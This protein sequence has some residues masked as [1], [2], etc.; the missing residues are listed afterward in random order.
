M[1]APILRTSLTRIARL[2]SF[3][4]HPIPRSQWAWG[5]YVVAEV[6]ARPPQDRAL[7]LADGRRMEVVRGDLVMG[8]FGTRAATLEITGTW[9]A[10]GA[11]RRMAALTSGGLFGVVTS[12]SP[13]IAPPIAMTYAGH[14]LVDGQKATMAQMVDPVPE[15][16]W[17]VPTILIVGSSM[18]AGKT[19]SARILIRR[20]R[21]LG[22]RVVAAKLTGAG[23][24]HDA[25][26]M[27]DAGAM[28][29]FDFVDA[30][31]PSTDCPREVFEPAARNLLSRMA[32]LEPDIAVIEA[33]ASP[34]E[35][36]NG[37][38]AV[39]LIEDRLA[40]LV[41]CASDPYAA[42][43]LIDAF[44]RSPDLVAGIAC[45]TQAGRALVKRLTSLPAVRMI[46][47]DA[48]PALDELLRERL[49]L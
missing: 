34:L 6:A 25:L 2:G 16:P 18:S 15:R 11:D 42:V 23:R 31:L 5:D 43:G 33:G 21:A 22:A 46:D 24:W 41:L 47:A 30:G 45:N 28:A 20:L 37:E 19:A 14:V 35:P 38:A 49:P 8:A 13:F 17:T 10:I 7:E 3:E 1:T 32:A 12:R 40:L 4:V 9:E 26:S 27:A 44:G 36:Y 48:L 39:E 29:A